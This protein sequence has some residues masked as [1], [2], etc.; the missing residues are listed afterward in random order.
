MDHLILGR[1]EV[2]W[3]FE[4]HQSTPFWRHL[5]LT[6]YSTRRSADYCARQDDKN[7]WALVKICEPHLVLQ[8]APVFLVRPLSWPN[9]DCLVHWKNCIPMELSFRPG[10]VHSRGKNAV[11][12]PETPECRTGWPENGVT[13]RSHPLQ[14]LITAFMS[15]GPP[16]KRLR[17]TTIDFTFKPQPPVSGMAKVAGMD[18]AQLTRDDR[19]TF[20]WRVLYFCCLKIKTSFRRAGTRQIWRIY[21]SS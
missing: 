14:P 6:W 21:L 19:T 3:R 16:L 10:N 20:H 2:W 1:D 18:G 7:R 13:M 4:A 17:Q 12:G 15:S 8:R 5:P 9:S 11:W